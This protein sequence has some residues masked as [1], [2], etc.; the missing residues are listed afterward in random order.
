MAS[1]TVCLCTDCSAVPCA[2]C[3]APLA[4]RCQGICGC[5]PSGGRGPPPPR[6]RPL[7][8]IGSVSSQ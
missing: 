3:R 1:A 8:R 2:N 7:E 5:V 4:R 6:A